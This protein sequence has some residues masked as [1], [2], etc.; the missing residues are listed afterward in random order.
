MP[1]WLVDRSQYHVEFASRTME[2]EVKTLRLGGGWKLRLGAMR[3]LG[4][5]KA[6]VLAEALL[7]RKA[8]TRIG[9]IYPG[10]ISITKLR[11]WFL[12]N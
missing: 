12:M 9:F 3:A 5:Y 2:I 10:H 4:A 11:C 8:N 1:P 6:L 7:C